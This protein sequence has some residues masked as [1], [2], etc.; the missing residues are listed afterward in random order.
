[1]H[2]LSS[3]RRMYAYEER[4]VATYACVYSRRERRTYE[5]PLTNLP[6]SSASACVVANYEVSLFPICY[7]SRERR[8]SFPTRR[9][10]SCVRARRGTLSVSAAAVGC[11]ARER[12]QQAIIPEVKRPN[13]FRRI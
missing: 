5:R 12:V 8:P 6:P 3:E 10:R 9:R 13:G 4:R 7:L 1:M 11:A 2:E